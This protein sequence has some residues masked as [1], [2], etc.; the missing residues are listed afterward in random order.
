MSF[1]KRLRCPASKQ[2][3]LHKTA[4]RPD[5]SMLFVVSAKSSEALQ[6]YIRRYLQFCITS[7]P[8]KFQDICYTSCV[9][10][11]HYRHRF[12]CVASN[13]DELI[14][15]LDERLQ[16]T[17]TPHRRDAPTRRVVFAFPGQGSHSAGMAS[18]LAGRFPEFAHIPP[19]FSNICRGALWIS[20][21]FFA[22]RPGIFF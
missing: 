21:S 8:D 3:R 1:L 20:Y 11:E 2:D 10:R 4:Y 7:I 19:Y 15:A 17:S 9:G 13:M 5:L 14:K 18:S 6:E 22:I 12:V 16:M